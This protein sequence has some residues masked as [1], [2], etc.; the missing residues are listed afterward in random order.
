[1]KRFGVLIFAALTLPSIAL[2]AAPMTFKNLAMQVIE[3]LDLST[4]TLVVFA[5]VAYFWGMAINITHFGGDDKDGKRQSFFLWGIVIL[6][7]MVSIWGIIKLLENTIF[8]DSSY[9]LTTG[10]SSA[11]QSGD[12]TTCDFDGCGN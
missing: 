9:D 5:I 7:V 6:F 3:L 10:Q 11:N 1:M 12:G 2:A 4:F 8:G